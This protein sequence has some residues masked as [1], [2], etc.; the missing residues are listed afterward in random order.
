MQFNQVRLLVTDFD[1]C[2]RFYR[3]IVGLE[4]LFGGEGDAYADFRIT[5]AI[6]FAI[7]RRSDMA[8]ATLPATHRA[9]AIG[10]WP[11]RRRR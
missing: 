5:D 8:Q 1:A 4:P 3:D 10:P 7:F 9:P 11:P 2:Y 6:S